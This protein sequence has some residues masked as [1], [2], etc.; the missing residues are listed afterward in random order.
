MK[1]KHFFLSIII[2][3]FFIGCSKE[4]DDAYSSDGF[5]ATDINKTWKETTTGLTI[6]ISGVSSSANGKGVIVSVGTAYPSGASGGTAM[7]E[8][9]HKS[10]GYWDA[11]NNTYYPSG[12]WVQGSVIGMSMN[13]AKT[14][15][16]IGS[17]VY[18]R[19]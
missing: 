15:F 13:A 17:K 19:Q 11:Y 10:G 7:T 5:T 16:K 14:E 9:E 1:L 12:N 3:L 18:K 8:V 4:A 2:S 6:R